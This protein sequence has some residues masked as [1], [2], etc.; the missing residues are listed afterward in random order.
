MKTTLVRFAFMAVCAVSAVPL[1][2]TADIHDNTVD[3]HD[4]NANIDDAKVEFEADVDVDNVEPAQQV[5]LVIVAEDVFLIDPGSTPPADRLKVAG[6]FKIYFDSMSSEPLL[7]TAEKN[8]TVTIPQ[9]APAG[10][11]K[12]IC[13]VHKHDGTP[14]E[15][16]FEVDIK[17][18][19]TVTN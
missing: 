18:K 14:T 16:T 10:D 15:A 19:A 3:V 5:Q 12:L 17:V 8:V 11:H 1:A 2:C 7:V 9:T 4:N 6:H 13:R